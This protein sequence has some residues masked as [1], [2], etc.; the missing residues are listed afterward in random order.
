[1]DDNKNANS[2]SSIDLVVNT[3]ANA[4]DEWATALDE[5]GKVNEKVYLFVLQ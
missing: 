1:M 3:D 5:D 4:Y 2:A